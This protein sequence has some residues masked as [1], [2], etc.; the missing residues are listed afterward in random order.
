MKIH[1]VGGPGSGKSF[2][3]KKLSREL[4][5]PHYDLDDIQWV[6]EG[7]TGQSET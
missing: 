2:L 1:I 3:A 5:I 7:A 4:G 6:N